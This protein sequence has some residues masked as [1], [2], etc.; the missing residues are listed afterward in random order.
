MIVISTLT[1]LTAAGFAVAATS[2][3]FAAPATAA[4]AEHCP[5]GGEKFEVD[6][7]PVLD[8]G[9]VD[10][11]VCIKTGPVAYEVDVV[12]GVIRSTVLNKP[13]T[14]YLGISYYVVYPCEYDCGGG[15][16][17]GS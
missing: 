7:G 16:T 14:A 8:I 13:G 3:V 9:D 12:D 4:T 1:K 11:T 2:A 15:G 5:D 6:A 17:G 10:G